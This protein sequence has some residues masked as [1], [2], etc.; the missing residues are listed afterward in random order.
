MRGILGCVYGTI[1][2]GSRSAIVGERPRSITGI[3]ISHD[4][5]LYV[6]CFATWCFTLGW[7]GILVVVLTF[8]FSVAAI[9]QIRLNGTGGTSCTEAR[10]TCLA[11]IGDT[12]HATLVGNRNAASKTHARVSNFSCLSLIGEKEAGV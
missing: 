2:D 10:L 3:V 8:S 1:D 9:V 5:D 12:P 6:Q 7:K 4:L 11:R